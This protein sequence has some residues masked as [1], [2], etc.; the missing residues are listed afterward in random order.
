MRAIWDS[1]VFKNCTRLT[2]QSKG[3]GILYLLS[4]RLRLS[5]V[6]SCPGPSP[7]ATPILKA[8]PVKLATSS[9]IST[10]QCGLVLARW[11]A[12]ISRGATVDDD[13]HP[14]LPIIRNI[15]LFP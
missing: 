13:T 2:I 7:E 5:E 1:K 10:L 15:P 12:K 9:L 3:L 8:D 4:Q 14:A 11:E 6:G